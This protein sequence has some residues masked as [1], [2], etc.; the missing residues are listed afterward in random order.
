MIVLLARNPELSAWSLLAIV[1]WPVMD[2]LFSIF[3]R[4]ANG[5]AT[6]KP[7]LLHF[8]QLIMRF[9]EIVSKKRIPRT[10]SNPMSTALILPLSF[11][12]IIIGIKYSHD[13]TVGI[14]TIIFCA[15]F[16]IS[17][18]YTLFFILKK[19]NFR[20]KVLQFFKTIS[21]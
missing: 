12:P 10:I 9:I 3:R 5:K 16:Y 17:I 15:F 19:K 13:V 20:N 7:D 4:V 8:H 14:I 2:T 21:H 11:F 1:F 18:Y 6:D